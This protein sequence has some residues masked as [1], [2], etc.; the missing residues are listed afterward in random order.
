VCFED[1]RG[2]FHN[3]THASD[4]KNSLEEM[5]A[6]AAAL[7][8]DYLG[9]A[10]HSK[11]SFQANGLSEERLL[12]QAEQIRAFNASG[13]APLHVFT[14]VECDILPDGRLDVPEEVRAQLDC[15]VVSVHSSF[16]RSE[17]EMTAR[18]IRAIEQPHVTMLGHLTGRLL[19]SREGYHVNFAKV[20]D[21]A[22]A[23]NVIIE[24]N[25]H[26]RRLDMDW[27][28]WRRAAERGMKTS[29]NPDAHSTEGLQL[30]R[31][32]INAARKGWLTRDSVINTLPLAEMKRWLAGRQ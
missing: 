20:I 7:G 13:K 19:L 1:L 25:A 16:S 23:N 28:H 22:L 26:P 4:G 24:I 5:A 9:I 31:A 15:V 21:A 17:D 12:K 6:A 30:T 3:H 11:A 32:G 27:R 29:I 10:D 14:G 18:I 8:W 2:V